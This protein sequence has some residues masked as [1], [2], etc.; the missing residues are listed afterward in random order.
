MAK[1]ISNFVDLSK[2]KEAA[3]ITPVLWS[4]TP[5]VSACNISE[6]FSLANWEGIPNLLSE[7]Y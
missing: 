6:Q 2:L 7:K 5:I 3:E 1:D 4:S